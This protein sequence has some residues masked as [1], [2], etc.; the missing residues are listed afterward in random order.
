MDECLY[1]R[2]MVFSLEQVDCDVAEALVLCPCVGFAKHFGELR[3]MPIE[4]GEY[5]PTMAELN[6]CDFG[7][8]PH[9]V[10]GEFDVLHGKSS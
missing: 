5:S 10:G 1:L 9:L 6:D 3:A 8:A 7:V 2:F 4:G